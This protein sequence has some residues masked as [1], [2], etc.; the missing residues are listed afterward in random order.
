MKTPEENKRLTVVIFGAGNVATHFA[1][2]FAQKCTVAHIVAR[3]ME[4]AERLVRRLESLRQQQSSPS[5]NSSSVKV[6]ENTG[7]PSVNVEAITDYSKVRPDA[8]LYLIAVSDD[9]VANVAAR[10]PDFPGIWAHTS[11]STGMEVFCGNKSRYGVFYP[12][13]TFSRDL[14]VD[15]SQVPMFIEGS[16]PEVSDELRRIASSIAGPV[17]LADSERRKKLHLAAVFA[18]NFANLMWLEADGLLK[19]DG[20]SVN[21]LRPLLTVTLD[22]LNYMSPREAM[23]GPA[24][25]GDIEVINSQLEALPESLRPMYALLSKSILDIYHPG[26][27]SEVGNIPESNQ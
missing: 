10:T 25:R 13:Q 17:E 9:E 1:E 26:L 18:C 12:L 7:C 11:G 15:M 2:A 8:D 23:T 27:V 20:L 3:T 22:K 6:E 21:F 14:D 16:S 24:R 5:G 19:K 4:S